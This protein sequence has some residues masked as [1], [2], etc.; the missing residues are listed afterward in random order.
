M[1]SFPTRRSSDLSLVHGSLSSQ[2]IGV[3]THL[4]V[5]GSQESAVQR[6][7]S[8]QLMGEP[9]H[10]T[11]PIGDWTQRTGRAHAWTPV[12]VR[13]GTPAC[14]CWPVASQKSLVHGFWS[15]QLSVM[16]S[17]LPV[18]GSQFP[19]TTLFRSSQSIGVLTHLPVAGSQESAVQRLPSSQLMGEPWHTT[20]PIGDWTQ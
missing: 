6:L 17:H 5:A 13:P 16:F 19:Y 14:G 1:H 8:S 18:S 11:P 10:T 2:S 12:T 9:W 4:P 7:P 15:S 3:L 20:P